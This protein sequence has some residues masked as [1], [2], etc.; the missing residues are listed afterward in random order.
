MA[1]R[2][3]GVS[4]RT[5]SVVRCEQGAGVRFPEIEQAR[6][7]RAG[8]LRPSSGSTV[9]RVGGARLHG[10]R[11]NTTSSGSSRTC[12]MSMLIHFPLHRRRHRW[13]GCRR[14]RPLGTHNLL[15]TLSSFIRRDRE[16]AEIKMRLATGPRDADRYRCCGKTRLALEVAGA[17]VERY[18]D[19]VWLVELAALVDTALPAADGG[20]GVQHAR[21]AGPARCHCHGYGSARTKPATQPR[22]HEALAVQQLLYSLGLLIDP[23]EQFVAEVPWMIRRRVGSTPICRN[24]S[25][26]RELFR[27]LETNPAARVWGCPRES[28]SDLQIGP[29]DRGP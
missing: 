26:H 11:P 8:R 17:V 12:P 6:Q 24:A 29:A 14:A 9:D 10:A 2:L 15:T 27:R 3:Q 20:R 18:A 19:G 13:T 23:T 1:A 5:E 28:K 4:K 21:D 16:E 25:V 22:I 7:V